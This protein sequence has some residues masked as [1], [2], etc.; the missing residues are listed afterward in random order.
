[1]S[2]PPS[3]QEWGEIL[4][5]LPA[6]AR[7]AARV[8]VDAA[9]QEYSNGTPLKRWRHVHKVA[10]S[11][12]ES[13]RE[14]ISDL[15][16]DPKAEELMRQVD[17]LQNIPGE[18]ATWA[19]HYLPRTKKARLHI[20]LLRAWT[21]AGKELGA[22]EDGPSQRF[23]CRIRAKAGISFSPRGAKAVIKREQERRTTLEV[24]QSDP[25]LMSARGNL[26]TDIQGIYLIDTSGNRKP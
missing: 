12:I 16:L 6:D 1:M 25:V 21:N 9:A 23:L 8:A 26:A 3:D 13:L 15:G 18:A 7:E 2:W 24:L 4:S 19:T 20:K 14:A 22:S 17:K 5:D 10:S 11:S